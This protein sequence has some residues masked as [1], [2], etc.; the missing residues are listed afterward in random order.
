MGNIWFM[1]RKFLEAEESYR[2]AIRLDPKNAEIHNLLGDLYFE[3]KHYNS[4]ETEYKT[5]AD[6]W[7]GN[8]KAQKNLGHVYMAQ[9]RFEKAEEAFNKSIQ[10]DPGSAAAGALPDS[11]TVARPQRRK[12]LGPRGSSFLLV[13]QG[14]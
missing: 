5:A 1:E 11:W 7:P 6:L 3:R 9:E 10:L 4:A 2:H 14:Y 8:A 13:P 12:C